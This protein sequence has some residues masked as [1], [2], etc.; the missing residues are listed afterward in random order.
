[1]RHLP[2]LVSASA[3]VQG[4]LRFINFVFLGKRKALCKDL[5]FC[6]TPHYDVAIACMDPSEPPN[7]HSKRRNDYSTSSGCSVRFVGPILF[8]DLRGEC[9]DLCWVVHKALLQLSIK[10]GRSFHVWKVKAMSNISFPLAPTRLDST[11]L[12]LISVVFHYNWV[13]SWSLLHLS[14]HFTGHWSKSLISALNE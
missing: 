14:T 3:A 7:R 12:Y 10:D 5:C 6:E 9:K 1:M 2:V 11:L 8:E 13:P 4:L